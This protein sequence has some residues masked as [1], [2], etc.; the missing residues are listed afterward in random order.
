MGNF[1][2]DTFKLTNTIYQQITGEAVKNPMH[3]VG[4]RLQQ[5]VPLVD[6]DWNELEDIR[7]YEQRAFLKWLVGDGVPQ[8]NDGFCIKDPK[9]NDFT[10]NNGVCFVN[11][12][13]VINIVK[14]QYTKQDLY[15]ND[16]LADKRGV[17][18]LPALNMGPGQYTVYLDVWE[19]EVGNKKDDR[20][21][22]DAIG[23][24]TCVR[25][26][27]EW[28]VRVEQG[29]QTPSAKPD[30]VHYKLAVL[31]VSS[32]GSVTV[33]DLRRTGLVILSEEIT[34][35]NGKVGIGTTTPDKL[36]LCILSSDDLW[37]SGISLDNR[38]AAGGKR[39]CITSNRGRLSIS[40]MDNTVD[41]LVIDGHG[42]IGIGTTTPECKLEINIESKDQPAL[43]LTG[44]GPGWGAA[45]E[46]NDTSTAGKK[47]DIFSRGGYLFIEDNVANRLVIDDNGNIGIGVVNPQAKFH[48]TGGD[49]RWGNN[50]CLREDQG[51]SI[52]LGGDRSTPG[53]GTPYI[54]FHHSG[55]TQDFNTRIINDADGRLSVIA[56]VFYISGNVGIGTYPQGALHVSVTNDTPFMIEG[57]TYVGALDH[58]PNQS[59][60]FLNAGPSGVVFGYKDGNGKKYKAVIPVTAL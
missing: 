26:K 1:S 42:N 32:V 53:K 46:L 27:R 44:A 17:D 22:N 7:K 43:R 16:K 8:G 58:S 21:V 12:W 33:T 34:I 18:P 57:A 56:P 10:I 19:R 49:L 52:E 60:I 23:I 6:A 30:H 48:I 5:G 50:S 25:I 59:L 38:L 28:V 15:N 9:A 29:D 40:D 54:D 24:E 55:L 36:P 20:I 41:R 39:Y 51:G 13:A 2:R 31:T 3:Y 14:T 35:K 47:Y 4:V 37:G 11:G 45:L